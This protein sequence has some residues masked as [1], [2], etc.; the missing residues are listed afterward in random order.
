MAENRA[1]KH[2]HDSGVARLVAAL[3]HP[4]LG[5]RLALLATLLVSPSLFIGFHLDDYVHRFLFSGLPGADALQRAYESP[6]GIANG[7]R[8]INHWQIENGYAPFWI[9]PELL[10]SLYRPVSELSHALDAALF[11]DNALLQHAHNLAWY[12]LLVL[13]A[14]ALY[15]SLLGRTTAAGIAAVL[16]AF[17][18]THGF[19]VGWIANRNAVIAACLGVCALLLHIKAREAGE[20]GSFPRALI[21]AA[22][23]LA[24]LLAGEG[25]ISIVGFILAHALLLDHGRIAQRIQFL[26][27][28]LLAVIVWRAQYAAA[29]RGAHGSGLYLDPA[30]EPLQFIAAAF[31]RMPVLL[32]GELFVPPA[33]AYVFLPPPWPSLQLGL[34]VALAVALAAIVWP[35]VRRDRTAAF[36]ALGTLA[37]LVPAVSTHPNN[38]LLFFV[39][40]GAMGLLSQLWHALIGNAAWLPTSSTYRTLAST[41]CAGL[42]GFHLVISPLLLPLTSMSVALTRPAR[43]A[44]DE[45]LL[46]AGGR[47]VIVLTAPDYYYTKLV[48]PIAALEDRPAPRRLRVLSFGAVPVIAQRID[49]RTLELR[50]EGGLLRE[51]LLELYRSQR[52]PL[53]LG[54]R[55]E[56]EGLTIEVTALT[57]DG[58]V[59]A[60][61]CAFDQDLDAPQ[62]RF[63]AWDGHRLAPFAVPHVGAGARLPPARVSFG[64]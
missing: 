52:N 60:V 50:Y 18:H 38:R 21:A 34:A 8:A 7:E 28:H 46:R 35:L 57:D 63:L 2:A 20:R 58:H 19:A 33:E 54:E 3:E 56:L 24:A 14:T 29:G 48:R 6:F 1:E 13:A 43:A 45:I 44:A 47:D 31:E 41:L 36:F 30:H 53:R 40:L 22:V 10:V 17:D 15:R 9:D 37:A 59:A 23:L 4:Q 42:V 64:F 62:L 26:V 39:G 5:L 49:R 61:R 32:L 55:I 16:Y 25:A 27:P 51:P 12:A 11:P